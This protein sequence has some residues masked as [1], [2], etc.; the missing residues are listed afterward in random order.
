MT[1]RAPFLVILTATSAIALIVAAQA[2]QPSIPTQSPPAAQSSGSSNAQGSRF[3][4]EDRAAFF[5]TR[6][7]AIRTGLRLTAA[8]E[9]MWPPLEAAARDMAK[10]ATPLRFAE[11][12]SEASPSSASARRQ[13][14]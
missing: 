7:A 4:A 5:E 2:Q 10:Q 13:P 3:T 14:I 1:K 9:V 12:G 8:Q 6:L 11:R